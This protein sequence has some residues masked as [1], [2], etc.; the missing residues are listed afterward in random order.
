MKVPL[1]KP[2]TD[3]KEV[4]AVSEVL[5][6]GWLINGPKVSEFE[7]MVAKYSHAKYAI[8]VGN[9]TSAISLGLLASGLSE[10]EPIVV[11]SYTFVATANAVG[12]AG[13]VPLIQDVTLPNGTLDYDGAHD[14]IFVDP[15][16]LRSWKPYEWQEGCIIIEDAACAIGA[17]DVGKDVTLA[18]FSFHASKMITTGEGGMIITD[19]KDIAERARVI[20]NQGCVDKPTNKYQPYGQNFRMTD[21]QG[22]M[23]IEQMKKLPEIIMRREEIAHLYTA[24]IVRAGLDITPPQHVEGRVYQ[25]YTCTVEKD[26]DRIKQDLAERGIQ[27]RIGTQAVH[28]IYGYEDADYPNASWLEDHTLSL[29]CF[30]SLTDKELNYVIENLKEVIG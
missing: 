1:C 16:G 25:S 26:R 19:D 8:A 14:Y 23:G 30:P 15:L 29:P 13:L 17:K 18:T 20:R 10:V 2:F 11:P 22:A 3:E 24:E 27:T 7:A 12:H 4:E 6:S 5:R 21:M 9:G 28:R